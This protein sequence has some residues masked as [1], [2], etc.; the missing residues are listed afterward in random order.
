MAHIIVRINLLRLLC[1][2][3]LLTS[4]PRRIRDWVARLLL[5]RTLLLRV[6]RQ[7]RQAQ[8]RKDQRRLNPKSHS[9][10]AL[11]S[12]NNSK[13]RLSL[14]CYPSLILLLLPPCVA[15]VA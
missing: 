14:R 8:C 3:F 1:V 12:W 7:P 2:L 10:V 15:T 11:P 6:G 5:R 9:H 13:T 4:L